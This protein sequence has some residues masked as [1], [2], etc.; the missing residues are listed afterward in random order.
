MTSFLSSLFGCGPKTFDDVQSGAV[1]LDTAD[2]RAAEAL[3]ASADLSAADLD[4][5]EI[6]GPPQTGPFVRI[7]EGRITALSLLDVTR[8]DAAE[9]LTAL[10]DLRLSGSFPA[11]RLRG[12]PDLEY[13]QVLGDE[14]S[15]VSLHLEDLP[16]L[17]E[18]SVHG[19]DLG[20]AD[21]LT[22]RR[23][24]ALR[25]LGLVQ[26]GLSG[27]PAMDA[28]GVTH[29]MVG[30]NRLR[31]LTGLAQFQALEN[32]HLGDN[33]LETVDSLPKLPSLRSLYL[34][35]NPLRG[36][37]SFQAEALPRL[38][39]LDLQ[40]TGRRAA[41]AAFAG[42]EGFRVR[43][44]PG[45]A[46]RASFEV[47]LDAL[48]A[49]Q[50]D[51]PGELVTRLGTGGGTLRDSSGRCTWKTGS[52]S[53]ARVECRFTFAGLRGLAPVRLG[54]TDPAMPFSGGGTPRIRAILRVGQGSAALY[55]RTA[56]DHVALARS[57][58]SI[59]DGVAD[60]ARRPE[61]RFD[62]YRRVVATP[63][64]PASAEGEPS[65]LA[66]DVLLWLE[67]LDGGAELL[68]LVVEP[69]G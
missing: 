53:R 58:H 36:D 41:P 67:A 44:D 57:I 63:E 64:D 50:R 68:E 29:L 5:A 43:L 30:S 26:C 14:A 61:D 22:L 13:V 32:L 46:E 10:S 69:A 3:L 51:A 40:R 15:P 4:L 12:L 48:R 2:R 59:N 9:A 39:S 34:T 55:V 52:F 65:I 11:L 66:G 42:R 18:V 60:A 23:V 19:G 21:G 17:R 1:P 28:P 31:D 45:I 6:D 56:F 27:I 8:T 24:P 37:T 62:G 35:G 33:G 25:S 47:M 54:T 38:D 20:G 49:G 16:S 7:E